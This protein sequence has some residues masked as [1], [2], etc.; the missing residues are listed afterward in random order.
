MNR[1]IDR[2]TV[3]AGPLLLAGLRA[4]SAK[5][6]PTV[7][8]PKNLIAWCIVPFDAKRRGPEERAE[9]LARLGI[10]H[11][12]YDWRAEHL[13]TL[14]RELDALSKH[15]IGLDA[16]W[17]PASLEPE[18]DEHARVILDFLRRR[19]VKPQLWISMSI[20][21]AGTTQEL[22]IETAGRA[23]RHVAG[24]A[25][26]LGC[27][28]ALYNHGGWFGEPENQIAII[29]HLRV[30]NVGIVYNFHHG[31]EH[32]ARWGE[33]FPKMKPH[34]LALN[35]NGMKIGGPKILPVGDGDRELEMLQVVRKSGWKG[36]VGIL[37]HREEL[38]A[39]VALRL[40]L[41]GLAKLAPRLR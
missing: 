8:D 1:P 23:I 4:A 22:R 9:M 13:P 5:E 20:P 40:N 33:L 36:P 21:E 18:K 41:E 37:G 27:K 25:R 3:L 7:S 29:E 26:T 11:F 24:E 38:D 19:G 35:I 15:G 32:V 6:R 30:P 31:H 14:D 2:R 28:V 17:Y 34:L 39:E 16:F 12:A 10:R